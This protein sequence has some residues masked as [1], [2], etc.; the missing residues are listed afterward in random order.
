MTA[1]DHRLYHRAELKQEVQMPQCSLTKK[2]QKQPALTGARVMENTSN[3]S[4]IF[5]AAC[6]KSLCEIM[7][8]FC[9][10]QTTMPKQRGAVFGNHIWTMSDTSQTAQRGVAFE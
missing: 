5:Q 10:V 2:Q 7:P 4:C 3:A 8:R 1:G 9:C 6:V